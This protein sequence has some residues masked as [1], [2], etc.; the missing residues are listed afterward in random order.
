MKKYPKVSKVS[1]VYCCKD[2]NAVNK[3]K[4]LIYETFSCSNIV[5]YDY[6]KETGA[7]VEEVVAD[8]VQ[9]MV[10]SGYGRL[11][12]EEGI[13]LLLAAER[14]KIPVYF[15]MNIEDHRLA[16]LAES[17]WATI[18]SQQ[19]CF[20]GPE[21]TELDEFRCVKTANGYSIIFPT[22]SI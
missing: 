9:G 15:I 6:Y 4:K 17:T 11:V 12:T 20:E 5:C 3:V 18:R 22:Y 7:T 19:R 8:D 2:V 10:I 14:K 1:Y 13:A 21:I 16:G